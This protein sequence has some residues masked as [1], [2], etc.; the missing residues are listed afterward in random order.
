MGICK[1]YFSDIFLIFFLSFS[2]KDGGEVFIFPENRLRRKKAT[3]QKLLERFYKTQVL[4]E[5]ANDQN[6]PAEESDDD[7][8]FGL[9]D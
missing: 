8:G 9:F 3:N 5:N 2:D 6:L 7:M 1:V 4:P